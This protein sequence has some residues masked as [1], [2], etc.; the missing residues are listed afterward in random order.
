MKDPEPFEDAKPPRSI[1][2]LAD[3]FGILAILFNLAAYFAI[4]Y[5]A[6]HFVTKYW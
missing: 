1:F 2:T 6:F 3:L 4:V 5:F